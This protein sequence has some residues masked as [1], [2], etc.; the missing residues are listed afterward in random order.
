MIKNVML[1]EEITITTRNKVGILADVAMMLANKGINIEAVLG[2]EVGITGKLLL[3]TSANIIIINELRKKR[4]KLVK[5]RE[6]ILVDLEN[7]PGALKVV[8]TE[9]KENKIDIKYAYVT[10]CT[11]ANKGS[12][13][14]VLQTSDNERAMVLLSKYT[15]E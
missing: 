4:Y 13:R 8:A 15:G 2:Y 14:M 9:M 10:P 6:V 3:I 7:K 11:C 12:S 5:E 1:G